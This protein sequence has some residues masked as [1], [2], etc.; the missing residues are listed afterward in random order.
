MTC[1][2]LQPEYTAFALGIADEPERSE[3]ESHLATNC[4]NCVP[5]VTSALATVTAMSGAVELKEPPRDLR[6]RITAMVAPE[7][8]RSWTLFLP[9]AIAGVLAVA[10][11]VVS[12]PRTSPDTAKLE[13]ALSI[14]NDPLTKDVTFGEAKPAK[15]R[16]FVSPTRGVVFIATNL[17]RLDRGKTFQLWV[18][19]KSGKP[20]PGGTFRSELYISPGPVDS[21]AAAVAVTVEPDGGSP[22]PTTT[23]FIVAAL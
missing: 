6:R 14:L 8:K 3:I 20:I 7:P 9:W 23:P 10:L 16:V 2:E 4:P 19:P 5:G 15:G 1:E 17:P 22:Q 13:Q 11:V 18:I 12:V 21:G